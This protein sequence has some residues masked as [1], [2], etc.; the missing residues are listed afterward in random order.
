MVILRTVKKKKKELFIDLELK[1]MLS[2]IYIINFFGGRGWVFLEQI[3]K[4]Y[5][6]WN[7]KKIPLSFLRI[8]II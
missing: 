1:Y 6:M 4:K 8:S 7:S 2:S 5:L 3:G